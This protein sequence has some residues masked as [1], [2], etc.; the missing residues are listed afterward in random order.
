[1]SLNSLF[2]QYNPWWE[3]AAH[4]KGTYCCRAIFTPIL[5]SLE[6]L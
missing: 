3:D 6:S 4:L 2:Y 5:E 1:M